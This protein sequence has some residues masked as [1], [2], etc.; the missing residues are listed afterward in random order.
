MDNR[1]EITESRGR[2]VTESGVP[3]QPPLPSDEPLCAPGTLCE[4][5]GRSRTGREKKRR[6]WS[7]IRRGGNLRWRGDYV[8]FLFFLLAHSGY[9]CLVVP[10]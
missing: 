8:I 7:W 4:I 10:P 2:G 1:A 6:A 9:W 3:P 5:S